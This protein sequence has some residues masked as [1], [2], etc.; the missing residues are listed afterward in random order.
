[1]DYDTV[2]LEIGEFGRWQQLAQAW[3]WIPVIFCGFHAL[4]YSF[5]GRHYISHL[6]PLLYKLTVSYYQVC[7][8]LMASDA[9][10]QAVMETTFSSE[11]IQRLYFQIGSLTIATSF[12]HCA[13]ILIILATVAMRYLQ[14]MKYTALA[15]WSMFMNHSSLR[16]PWLPGGTWC[17]MRNSRCPWC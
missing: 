2:L 10:S 6:L 15:M 8:Q 17:V 4:L 3:L 9:R 13:M 5:T 16:R 12:P 7:N 11:I 14:Q 1:M